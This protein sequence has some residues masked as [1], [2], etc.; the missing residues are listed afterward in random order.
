MAAS[1]LVCTCGTCT[2]PEWITCSQVM[3]HKYKHP[4]DF[5]YT[6]P[7]PSTGVAAA[8]VHGGTSRAFATGATRD[9]DDNK[10]DFE[11]FLSPLVIERYAEHMHVARK[12]PDG[13]MRSS[14]NWQLGIPI[15]VY[16]KSMW[17]HFFAVWKLHRGLKVT[18]VVRGETIVKDIETELC[19]LRFNV[20]GMLHEILKA[21]AAKPQSME[22]LLNG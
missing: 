7:R 17:R 3:A 18:E 14:D 6:D 11:G 8:V 21:K 20:D 12:M 13:T 16:M 9:L 5:G 15:T 22:D 19:A 2:D 1:N 10:L 4:D